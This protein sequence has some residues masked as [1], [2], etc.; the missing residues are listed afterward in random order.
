MTDDKKPAPV[1]L[2]LLDAVC[3]TTGIYTR[4][5]AKTVDYHFDWFTSPL[6]HTKTALTTTAGGPLLR[7]LAEV[8]RPEPAATPKP[9]GTVPAPPLPCLLRFHKDVPVGLYASE[10]KPFA[11]DAKRKALDLAVVAML[12]KTASLDPATRKK[13]GRPAPQL[14]VR[15]DVARVVT[16]AQVAELADPLEVGAELRLAEKPGP[17]EPALDRSKLPFVTRLGLHVG[18]AADARVRVELGDAAFKN[19]SIDWRRG[20]PLVLPLVRAALLVARAWVV[21][22]C[23]KNPAV[24][25]QP[26]HF[27]LRLRDHLLPLLE[28]VPNV[29][30]AFPL[31]ACKPD[32]AALKPWLSALV[33]PSKPAAIVTVLLHLRALITG[34]DLLGTAPGSAIAW[35]TPREPGTDLT[36]PKAEDFGLVIRTTGEVDRGSIVLGLR[37]QKSWTAANNTARVGLVLEGDL[38][39]AAWEG[40]VGLGPNGLA[41]HAKGSVRTGRAGLFLVVE[42][43]DA[44][45]PPFQRLEIGAEFSG[46]GIQTELRATLSLPGEPPG[47][48]YSLVDLVEA[49]ASAATRAQQALTDALADAADAAKQAALAAANAAKQAAEALVAQLRAGLKSAVTDLV[50]ALPAP[51]QAAVLAAIDATSVDAV[52]ASAVR[53]IAELV[54]WAKQQASFGATIDL[55]LATLDVAADA[56]NQT[57]KLTLTPTL[58]ADPSV[59]LK[60]ATG[61]KV[62]VSNTGLKLTTGL[63]LAKIDGLPF[64]PAVLCTVVG[65]A[66]NFAFELRGSPQV[67]ATFSLLGAATTPQQLLAR[68]VRPLIVEATRSLEIAGFTVAQLLTALGLDGDPTQLTPEVIARQVLTR[69]GEAAGTLAQSAANSVGVALDPA[70]L[71]VSVNN[72][73]LGS[74]T[75]ERLGVR[76]LSGDKI[77]PTVAFKGGLTLTGDDG[78]PVFATDLVTL[79]SLTARTDLDV[80]PPKLRTIDLGF[81]DVRLPLGNSGDGGGGLLSTGKDNPGIHVELGWTDP[82]GF[83]ARFK[84]DAP[85]LD[86][87]IDRV[88][89]PLDVRRLSARILDKKPN[90]PELELTLDAIFKL[91]GVTIAPQGLGVILP[92]ATLAEP[93]SWRPTLGGLTLAY[94]Q[95]GVVLAGSLAKTGTGY[96]G[97]AIIKAFEFQIAAAAAYDKVPASGDRPGDT[98]SSLAVFGVLRAALGGPPFFVIT[99]VAAGF[100]VN[101]AFVKPAK[102]ADL[103]GNPLLATMQGTPLTMDQFRA[104]L[105]VKPGAFWLAGGVKFV[106]YGFILG[107]ALI[108]ILLD[109]GFELGLIALASM[110][111]PGLLAINLAI[112]A[113]LSFRGEPTL[114]A[115]AALF[116]SW[117]LHPDCKIT[118]GFALQVWPRLGDAVITLG[119]YHPAFK[120][121]DN[122]P[123]VE[124]LGFRWALG[125]A[126]TVK[127]GCYFAMT[128]R[129][130]MGGGRL[131]VEGHWGPL[132]A[133]F[134]V[135]A[136]GLFRWDPFYFD[137][138]VEVGIWGAVDLWFTTLR[139][140]LGVGLHVW[141][142]PVGGVASIDLGV[143]SAD[144]PFG[145][146]QLPDT[147]A[148]P[149]ARVLRDH[150]HVDVPPGATGDQVTWQNLALLP[151]G[152]DAKLP[153]RLT[154]VSGR[155]D[156]PR[157]AATQTTLRLRGEFVLRVEPALP[158]SEVAVD[159]QPPIV[160]PSPGDVPFHLTLSRRAVH[161]SSLRVIS[162]TPD[163][164][165]T[166][167]ADIRPLALFGPLDAIDGVSSNMTIP[168]TVAATLDFSARRHGEQLVD[169]LRPELADRDEWCPLPLGRDASGALAR[170]SATPNNKPWTLAALAQ[171]S[172]AAA[173]RAQRRGGPLPRIHTPLAG[174]ATVAA[175]RFYGHRVTSPRPGR[176]APHALVRW[177]QVL[178]LAYLQL[179]P[180]DAARARLTTVS[181]AWAEVPRVRPTTAIAR[182]P[183]LAGLALHHVVPHTRPPTPATSPAPAP[184]RAASGKRLRS[185]H[186][187]PGPARRVP[188]VLD[189]SALAHHGHAPPPP[190]DGLV[191]AGE[192]CVTDLA[193]ADALR[194]GTWR[195][196]ASGRQHLRLVALDS[197]ARVLLDVALQPGDQDM[198]LPPGTRRLALIGGG[199]DGPAPTVLR[200]D[201]RARI[202]PLEARVGRI[203]GARLKLARQA[204]I[205]AESTTAV[206]GF[207]EATTLVGL[208][209]RV[210][211]VPGGVVDVQRQAGDPQRTPLCVQPAATVLAGTTALGLRLA[212]PGRGVLAVHL[213]GL[214]A[215]P[216]L[217]RKLECQAGAG[218]R[219]R[220]GD[221][222]V[223]GDAALVAFIAERAERFDV[224]V[225]RELR[226]C[227]LA[228]WPDRDALPDDAFGRKIHHLVRA[229]RDDTR[230]T[231]EVSR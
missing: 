98:I 225:P 134:H 216:E 176:L 17:G 212:Q 12:P 201:E 22:L 19:W 124:R 169:Q 83:Y 182:S 180:A 29:L 93:S 131:E 88:I 2:K 8:L 109:D 49:A 117:L 133:G 16:G 187:P 224:S 172:P 226:L 42:A 105:P 143:F 54:A 199:S 114:Y 121:P 210:L 5:D 75:V 31:A 185:V 186:A 82:A 115:K 26:P 103:K 122:Y 3:E 51:V 47:K 23:E 4:E 89:G 135:S 168:L 206:T 79:G 222:R 25:D 173:A 28:G 20:E 148:L 81:R 90:L 44:D 184:L 112:E 15:A 159:G 142:P 177:P 67:A 119:G 14:L 76:L 33:D 56:A 160:F 202:S 107:D 139:F 118:G 132:A 207:G 200:L 153:L 220:G 141:G 125:D 58:T 59:P 60:L 152:T 68:V 1:T 147:T 84:G 190:T 123:E 100:G 154:V 65:S 158:L 87:P 166:P 21:W 156:D 231:L 77:S 197:A 145:S 7:A 164:L 209:P 179:P 41:A 203:Q 151:A 113:G 9:D 162:P 85:R 104:G 73:S 196:R 174:L 208:A 61:S 97:Q 144:I 57:F 161:R 62:E 46:A 221:V 10:G 48:R 223:R 32:P 171:L 78:A 27:G 211:L 195:L 69:L 45:N 110:K 137:I 188:L 94:D 55:G 95:S 106:S 136:D 140:S 71:E 13:D 149:V 63:E 66:V 108:Y 86:L 72:L 37:G 43:L 39:R 198:V 163:V 138:N 129:E 230:F 70:N 215:Q 227:G 146:D 167:V 6:V 74:A 102:T 155:G 183:L 120:R 191:R 11:A 53:M 130:A 64:A 128:P 35:L 157:T 18:V 50:V 194:A 80:Y 116:D 217:L 204:P 24:G 165:A 193:R 34:K 96:A 127:G 99:G 91:G 181:A 228:F 178:E 150:L 229:H 111:L 219:L 101:R 52:R 175:A 192:V 38:V 92:F 30:P 213:A 170:K 126:I 205:A 40:M 218:P 189:P 214:S 36:K